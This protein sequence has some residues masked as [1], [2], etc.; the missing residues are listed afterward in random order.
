MRQDQFLDVID[1]DEA[2]RRFRAALDLRPLPAEAVPL[3]EAL[4][5]VLARDVLA[6]LAAPGL[7]RA[8][9]CALPARAADTS[10]ASDDHARTLHLNR[11]T[12][13]TG[14]APAE[15]VAPGTATAIATGAVLPRGADAVLMVE[16]TDV[17]EG[18]VIL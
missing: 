6:P 4:H 9:W 17:H 3:T 16:F 5:R 14:R 10:G 13:T 15:P 1:R 18:L 11:D 7:G 8:H 2:E 12:L